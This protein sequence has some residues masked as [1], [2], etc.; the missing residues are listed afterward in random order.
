MK[1]LGKIARYLSEVLFG[2]FIFLI[3]YPWAYLGEAY[4]YYGKPIICHF[5]GHKPIFDGTFCSRCRRGIQ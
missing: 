2:T 3:I 5:R 1:F 4:D